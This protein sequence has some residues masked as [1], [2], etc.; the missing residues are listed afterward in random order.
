M[1]T[2]EEIQLMGRIASGDQDA[3]SAL[4]VTYEKSMYAFVL[5][6]LNDPQL[7]A[8]I[9]HET[10]LSIWKNP[11]GFQGKSK[12]R[13]WLFQI[14]H[15]KMV[16]H[17]RK[18]SRHPAEEP[19]ESIVDEE[20]N[21]A[22]GLIEAAQNSE[23]LKFCLDKLSEAHKMVVHMAYFEEMGY[24]EIASIL[25]IPAGTVKTRM[26]HAKQLLKKCLSM[27]IGNPQ[28]EV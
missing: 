13:T 9:V 18:H 2:N 8:D 20:D 27:R 12:L 17:L 19:D 28:Q 7:A 25:S 6:K 5:K 1:N 4:Y 10:M 23:F 26:F 14:A 15:N 24:D 16:D 21:A 3:M 11:G 22:I